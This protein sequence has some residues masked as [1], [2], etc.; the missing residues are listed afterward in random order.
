MMMSQGCFA[1]AADIAS[2]VSTRSNV[3]SNPPRLSSRTTSRASCSTS[4][5][6]NAR[7]GFPMIYDLPVS[8]AVSFRMSQYKPSCR[9]ASMNWTKSTGFRT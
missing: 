1:S 2:G 7:S 5:T 4:S 9:T 3:T 8:G 6:I